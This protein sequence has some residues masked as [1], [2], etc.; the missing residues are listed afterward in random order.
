MIC[1]ASPLDGVVTTIGGVGRLH[2]LE[3]G[4]ADADR[5]EEAAIA[6][7]GVDEADRLAGGG[8][9]PA[10]VAASGHAPDED[11]RIERVAD[12]PHAVAQDRAPGEGARGVDGNHTDAV[13]RRH[14][15]AR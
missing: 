8:R 6:A 14:S 11:P 15:S 12:H 4:L 5:L 9:E 7:G 10:E 1:T 2:D 3:L 13:A